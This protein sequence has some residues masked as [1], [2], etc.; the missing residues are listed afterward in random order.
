MQ[1]RCRPLA[2]LHLL[3]ALLLLGGSAS[4]AGERS[5]EAVVGQVAVPLKVVLFSGHRYVAPGDLGIPSPVPLMIHG[6]ARLFL[7]LTHDV[8]ERVCGH[9]IEKREEYG[10]SSRGKGAID[11]PLMR[12]GERR[13][14][15]LS[16]VPVFDFTE[17]GDSTVGGMLGTRFLMEAGAAVDF[18][19]DRL[20]LGVARVD[21]PNATLVARGYRY[22]PVTVSR[23][24]RVTIPAYFP[25]LRRTLPITPSTVSNALTLHRPL[26]TGKVR[27][28]RTASPDRS[29]H[30]TTP[31]EYVGEVSFDIVGVAYRD[32]A[33]FEDLAEYANTPESELESYGMLGF[34]WMTRHRAILDYA[35]RAL[36]FLR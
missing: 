20:V 9:V 22:V 32:T 10:Y 12:L 1:S 15:K 31:E 3:L 8:A 23:E 36:Y 34:D 13:F 7:S 6:N 2:L 21:G 18:S 27:M 30:G 26:F 25:R 16:G 11:V 29:P 35:N 4:T 24:G 17:D 14:E 33:L 19:R 5:D 28:R